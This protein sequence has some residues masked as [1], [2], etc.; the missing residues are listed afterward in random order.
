MKSR[1]AAKDMHSLAF[2][3]VKMIWS[4]SR[5]YPVEHMQFLSF[6][7]LKSGEQD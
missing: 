2:F 4:L 3:G 5:F 6:T 7:L 1:D